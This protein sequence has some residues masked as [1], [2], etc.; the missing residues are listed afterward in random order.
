VQLNC[1]IQRVIRGAI[2]YEDYLDVVADLLRSN[3]N[4]IIKLHKVRRGV[5]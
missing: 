5:V 2:V 3:A 4:T 1:N